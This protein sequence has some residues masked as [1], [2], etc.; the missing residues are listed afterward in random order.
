MSVLLGACSST[1]H[2][3]PPQELGI[4]QSASEVGPR[5]YVFCDM[6]GGPWGCASV[7]QKTPAASVSRAKQIVERQPS[8]DSADSLHKGQGSEDSA[9][10]VYD[11]SKPVGEILFDFDSSDIT[12]RAKIVLLDLLDSLRGKKLLFRGY[13]DAIGGGDY[14]DALAMRRALSVQ[15]FFLNAGF[16]SADLSVEGEG[17]CC[18]VASNESDAGRSRNRRVE[19]FLPVKRQGADK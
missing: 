10:I 1:I 19:I 8:P 3:Q 16:S 13:T 7:S 6:M 14:N 18:Y 5:E 11:G 9:R 17:L 4:V 15:A 12:P 2:R